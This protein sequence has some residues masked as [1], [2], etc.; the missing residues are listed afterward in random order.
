MIRKAHIHVLPSTHTTGIQIKL[1]NALYNGRHCVVNDAMVQ[2]TGLEP[3]CFIG[4]TANAMQEI[5][6]QLHYKPFTDEELKIRE[7]LLSKMFSNEANARQQVQWIWG[8]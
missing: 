4:N 1:L 6:A 2:G 5:I 7:R 3:A 8:E